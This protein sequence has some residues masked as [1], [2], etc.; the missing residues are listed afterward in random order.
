[1]TDSAS[2]AAQ[3]QQM[4]LMAQITQ[5]INNANV[6]PTQ[7]NQGATVQVSFDMVNTTPR[8]QRLV[9]DLCVHFIKANGSARPKVFKLREIELGA[10][11]LSDLADTYLLNLSSMPQSKR[12]LIWAQDT[13]ARRTNDKICDGESRHGVPASAF[14]G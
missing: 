6:S 3:L 13:Q 10:S 12:C 14:G 9:V 8:A 4:Q 2:Q 11:S 5:T 7:V 1:M